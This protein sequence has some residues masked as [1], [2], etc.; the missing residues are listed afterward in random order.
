MSVR[1]PNDIDLGPSDK[2]WILHLSDIGPSDL[3]HLSDMGFNDVNLGF[4]T[5]C[6]RKIYWTFGWLF[7]IYHNLIMKIYQKYI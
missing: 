5:H 4:I 7:I 1:K 3:L 2:G 6:L